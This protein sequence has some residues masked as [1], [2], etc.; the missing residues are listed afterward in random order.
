METPAVKAEVHY[1]NKHLKYRRTDVRFFENRQNN[2][3]D[4][5]EDNIAFFMS[6]YERPCNHLKSYSHEKRLRTGLM[7]ILLSESL[8]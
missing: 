3:T 7:C 2:Y 1:E 5:F 6:S 8:S 4:H